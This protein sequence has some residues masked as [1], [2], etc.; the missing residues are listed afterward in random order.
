MPLP[1]AMLWR[2]CQTLGRPCGCAASRHFRNTPAQTDAVAPWA[3]AG[4]MFYKTRNLIRVV[5]PRLVDSF[6][7]H[8]FHTGT[9]APSSPAG[10]PRTK[11]HVWAP[12]HVTA[13]DG[14]SQN[15]SHEAFVTEAN[16]LTRSMHVVRVAK[17]RKV[18]SYS[19]WRHSGNTVMALAW[20]W[21]TGPS[22][23]RRGGRTVDAHL[24]G[25][26]VG[27]LS[28]LDHRND[29]SGSRRPQAHTQLKMSAAWWGQTQ[30][31]LGPGQ[32]RTGT[33]PPTPRSLRLSPAATGS[34]AHLDT[35]RSAPH[36]HAAQVLHTAQLA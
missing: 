1:G 33:G 18:L 6:R 17:A 8:R 12:P 24:Q 29:R 34:A 26:L 10:A 15:Y 3:L 27:W 28:V 9:C 11:G 14:G 36:A 31:G 20:P 7:A 2:T 22:G 5:C 32:P 23:G 25:R 16:T 4:C 35:L 13:R 19:P 21:P 30:R